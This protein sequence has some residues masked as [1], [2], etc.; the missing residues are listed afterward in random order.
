[1]IISIIFTFCQVEFDIPVG[2]KGDC[3]DR[4][5]CRVQEMR[6]SVRIISQVISPRMSLR[7]YG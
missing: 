5:I 4:Y 3:Y 7:I 6:E 2:R 1:M